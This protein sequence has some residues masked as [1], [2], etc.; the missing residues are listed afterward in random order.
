MRYDQWRCIRRGD[1]RVVVGARSA[2]FSPLRNLRLIIVDEEHDESYKQ[3]DR[4]RY[5]ARDLALVKGRIHRSTVILG[6]ATPA[7]QSYFNA[8]SGKYTYLSLPNRVEDRPLPRVEIVDMRCPENEAGSKDGLPIL[9]RRLKEALRETLAA[10]KQALLLLNRRGFNTVVLCRDCGHVLKCRNC[11]LTLTLHAREKVLTCHYCD[12][13][14][15]ES[16]A[17]PAC[18][19]ARMAGYGVGTERL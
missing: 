17:C 13:T 8:L 2:L 16:A 4:M 15:R 11:D 12:F 7:I 14:V 5:N 1:I 19:G 18:G 9:S 3:D 10:Q 6:S